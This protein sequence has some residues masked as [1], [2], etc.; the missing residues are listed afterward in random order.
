MDPQP[1]WSHCQYRRGI[2][3]DGGLRA[4]FRE[5]LLAVTEHYAGE[6]ELAGFDVWRPVATGKLVVRC[7]VLV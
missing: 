4:R 5:L 1:K 7:T 6:A 2:G 3:S